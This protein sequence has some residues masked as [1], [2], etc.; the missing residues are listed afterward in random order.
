MGTGW[1]TQK[2]TFYYHRRLIISMIIVFPLA[3][4]VQ[5]KNFTYKEIIIYSAVGLFFIIFALYYNKKTGGDNIAAVKRRENYISDH[6]D[7][8]TEYREAILHGK[9]VSGMTEELITASVG[10]PNRTEIFSSENDGSEVWIYKNGIYAYV[11]NGLLQNWKIHHKFI[12][13]S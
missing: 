13:F 12:S 5:F 3:L 1:E 6:P 10:H 4:A 11:H 2:I 9:L 8:N 7:L